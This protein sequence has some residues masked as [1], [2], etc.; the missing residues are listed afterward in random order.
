MDGVL[1]DFERAVVEAMNRDL[2]SGNPKDPKLAA[3]IF[4]DLGRNYIKVIDIQKYGPNKS[5]IAAKYMYKLVHDNEDFWANLPWQP[6]GKKLWEYIKEFEPE[7]LTAPMDKQGKNESLIGKQKW[8]EKNLGISPD[9][10]NFEH[11]K[12]QY[13]LSKDGSP[14]VLIDDFESKVKPFTEAGGIGILHISANNTIKILK[15]LKEIN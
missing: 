10:I 12:W 4:K 15:L 5:A 14:N 9:R 8:V 2:K 7:I 6:G 1:C 11:K 13:A 3:K